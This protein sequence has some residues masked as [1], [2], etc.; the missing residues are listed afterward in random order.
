[1]VNIKFLA[2]FKEIT[3]EK[4]LEIDYTGSLSDLID[5]LINKYGNNFKEALLG[6]NGEIKDYIKILVNGQDVNS[7]ESN[8]I[9]ENEDEIMIFQ[10]IAGG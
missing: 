5:L 2:R 1:M 4:T 8:D 3:G 6:K 10:A 7:L 9:I